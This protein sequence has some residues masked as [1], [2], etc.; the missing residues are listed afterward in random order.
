MKGPNFPRWICLIFVFSIVSVYADTSG[1]YESLA[2]NEQNLKALF[3]AMKTESGRNNLLRQ[4]FNET[5]LY[6]P[7]GMQPLLP[8]HLRSSSL[9]K[10]EYFAVLSHF[11]SRT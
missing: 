4:Y 7:Y 11:T 1:Y 10:T 2:I 3:S 5:F 6:R 9:N 8:A